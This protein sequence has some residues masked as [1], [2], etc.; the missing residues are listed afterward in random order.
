MFRYNELLPVR[1]GALHVPLHIGWTPLYHCSR[2]AEAVGVEAVFVK[3]DSL[4]PSASSKD[5][6]SAMVV[7]RAVELGYD[8]V[9]TASTGNAA[10]SLAACCCSMGLPCIVLVPAETPAAKLLQMRAFNACVIPVEGSYD[11]AFD[12]AR[13]ACETFGWMNRSAGYNPYLVEGKKTLAWEMAEQMRF[14]PPDAVAVSVGD[15]SIVSGICKGFGEMVRLGL[16]EKTP[17]VIGVQAEGSDVL[18]RAWN[19]WKTTGRLDFTPVSDPRTAADSICVGYPREGIRALRSVASTGGT[20]IAVDD[21]G[22]TSEIGGGNPARQKDKAGN[23]KQ[24]GN[25]DAERVARQSGGIRGWAGNTEHG[26][27]PSKLLP[28]KGKIGFFG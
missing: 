19:A 17:R 24:A 1:D 26:S 7:S 22:C 6:A 10:A 13:N 18:V 8:A 16:M 21:A 14:H 2:A 25:G 11:Q 9:C 4:N 12:I 3:D 23:E 20:F 15:G 28:N 5:R 27:S